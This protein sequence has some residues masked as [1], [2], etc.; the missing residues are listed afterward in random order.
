MYIYLVRAHHPG[1][2]QCVDCGAL[3]I[4]YTR[5]LHVSEALKLGTSYLRNSDIVWSGASEK[6][7]RNSAVTASSLIR[8]KY[9][10]SI[11]CSPCVSVLFDSDCTVNN[12]C[13][14]HT[15]PSHWEVAPLVDAYIGSKRVQT[16]RSP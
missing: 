5:C 16:S 3:G 12:S 9:A 11:M 15:L 1:E 7:W 14:Q 2:V 10:P 8:V 13:H 4:E 6:A